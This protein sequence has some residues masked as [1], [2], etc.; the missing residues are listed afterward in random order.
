[1]LARGVRFAGVALPA[2]LVLSA[3]YHVPAQDLHASRPGSAS[4]A[5]QSAGGQVAQTLSHPATLTLTT[6]AGTT[7]VDGLND[8]ITTKAIGAQITPLVPELTVEASARGA[9]LRLGQLGK[10]NRLFLIDD[11]PVSDAFRVSIRTSLI[12]SIDVVNDPT[13]IAQYGPRASDGVVL[14][15]T[16]RKRN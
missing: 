9:L 2:A 3:C 12:E 13:V 6:R 11:V 4:T 5:P 15:A 8:S 10:Y 7:I 1:M 16:S 14:I